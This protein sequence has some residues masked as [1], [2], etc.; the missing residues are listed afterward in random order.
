MDRYQLE[1]ARIYVTTEQNF[2][3]GNR[4][5]H[6]LELENH[7]SKKELMDAFGD[8]YRDEGKP[9][10][11]CMDWQN[12]PSCFIGETGIS[13]NLFPLI[14]GFRELSPTD[15]IGFGIWLGRHQYT[16]PDTDA[17]TILQAF[18][19]CYQGYYGFKQKFTEYYAKQELGITKEGSPHFDFITFNKYLFEDLYIIDRGFIFRK[20]KYE[21][22]ND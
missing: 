5:G 3:L 20:V 14:T 2:T 4:M 18:H 16:I 11:Y 7:A 12:I 22:N 9:V 19:L 13:D 8:L 10:I 17:K 21:F 1:N 6:W 15:K